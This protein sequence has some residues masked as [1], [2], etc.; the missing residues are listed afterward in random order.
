MSTY[1][2]EF[3]AGIEWVDLENR[4]IVV[5][6]SDPYGHQDIRL[7]VSYKPTDTVNDIKQ[8]IINTTPHQRFHFR[9]EALKQK[10]EDHSLE[11]M[12]LANTEMTY[13][14]PTF[15]NEDI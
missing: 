2:C 15:D 8:A 14:L 13:K 11:I 4:R 7:T 5:V 3:K 1:K 10:P 6:Y 12:N 9:N